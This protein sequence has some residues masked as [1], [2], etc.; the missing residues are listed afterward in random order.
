MSILLSAV[1]ASDDEDVLDLGAVWVRVGAHREWP[2]TSPLPR[3]TAPANKR[4]V[5][6]G[7]RHHRGTSVASR[8]RRPVDT[9]TPCVELDRMGSRAAGVTG[10][11]GGNLYSKRS[12]RRAPGF[13]F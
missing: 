2:R 11:E 4:P 3:P 6:L 5:A 12:W 7:D 13:W 8:L 9:N 10:H 1:L